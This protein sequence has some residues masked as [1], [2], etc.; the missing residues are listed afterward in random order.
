MILQGCLTKEKIDAVLWNNTIAIPKELCDQNPEL[1]K[2]GIY[3]KLNDGKYE[4][5]SWCN[6]NI[7]LYL[8]VL[9]DDLNK[10]IDENLPKPTPAP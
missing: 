6:E 7:N 10:L 4:F 2:H 5:V 3:R 1:K 9:G 8:S